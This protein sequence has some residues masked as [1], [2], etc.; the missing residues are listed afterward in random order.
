MA[1]PLCIITFLLLLIET[2][3]SRIGNSLD[4]IATELKN[5]QKEKTT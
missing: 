5:T 4:K 3:L 2:D 1:I